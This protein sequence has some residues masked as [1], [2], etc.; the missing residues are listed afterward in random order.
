MSQ[1]TFQRSHA[2]TQSEFRPATQALPSRKGHVMLACSP[3]RLGA[4]PPRG[5]SGNQARTLTGEM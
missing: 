5:T 4:T 2:E 1:G 3:S